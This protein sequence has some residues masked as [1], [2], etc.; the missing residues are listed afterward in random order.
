MSIISSIYSNPKNAAR[1]Y[2]LSLPSYENKRLLK[3]ANRAQ[4]RETRIQSLVSKTI[5][6]LQALAKNEP[7][8]RSA[9]DRLRVIESLLRRQEALPVQVAMLHGRDVRPERETG[10]NSLQPAV[11]NAAAVADPADVQASS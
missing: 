2:D 1:A 10:R 8:A 6:D 9:I 5:H 3:R 4:K 7:A 11:N